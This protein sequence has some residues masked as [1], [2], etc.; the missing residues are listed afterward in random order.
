MQLFVDGISVTAVTTFGP[1]G[2]KLEEKMAT[3][4]DVRLLSPF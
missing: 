2:D 3:K 4:K 1:T